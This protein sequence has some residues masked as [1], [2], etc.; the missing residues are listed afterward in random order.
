MTLFSSAGDADAARLTALRCA[1]TAWFMRDHVLGVMSHDLRG[2]LNAIHSW[3]YV[4]ERKLASSDAG[5]Q[6]ALDG[7]R[8]GVEQQLS[9]LETQVDATRA[10]TRTLTLRRT[11]LALPSLLDETVAAVRVAL[12]DARQV[13]LEI[14]T[15]S[16]GAEITLDG[17]RERLAA[18]LWLMLVFA[19]ESSASAAQARLSVTADAGQGCVTVRFR[20]TPGML[21]AS[22]VPH[23]LEA[24]ARQQALEPL[25]AGRIA[26]VLALCQRVALAHGGRFEQQVEVS[27]V[28]EASDEAEAAGTPAALRLWLPLAG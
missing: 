24:H 8:A 21:D 20:A 13:E 2:P 6:R 10:A 9:L 4:L 16:L 26:W 15:A 12:A 17:D 27:E 11:T 5:A 23:V 7:I 18:A 25:E 22:T 19:V 14:D 3:A 1:E 28:P